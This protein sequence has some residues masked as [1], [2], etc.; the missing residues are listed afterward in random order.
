MYL[1]SINSEEVNPFAKIISIKK[2]KTLPMV[3]TNAVIYPYAL[4]IKAKKFFQ[5]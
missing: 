1:A 5:L 4:W 2:Y 3:N